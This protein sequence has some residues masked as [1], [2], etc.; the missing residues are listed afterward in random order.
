MDS[1]VTKTE[2]RKKAKE[3]GGSYNKGSVSQPHP[4]GSSPVGLLPVGSSTPGDLIL[5][6]LN[7]EN[8]QDSIGSGNRQR[9]TKTKIDRNREIQVLQIPCVSNFL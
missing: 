9:Q 6:I 3:G 5:P 2:S 4:V 8:N 1:L 7:P